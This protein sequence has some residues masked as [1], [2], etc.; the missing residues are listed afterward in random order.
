MQGSKP[1]DV[2]WERRSD[3]EADVPGLIPSAGGRRYRLE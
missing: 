1:L 2:A 3:D